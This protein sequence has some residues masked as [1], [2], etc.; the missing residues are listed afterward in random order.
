MENLKALIYN[1]DLT[2]YQRGLAVQEF[3]KLLKDQ[4]EMFE[5]MQYYMEYCEKNGYVTPMDW[6]EKYK[7]F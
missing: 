1:R 6:I 5:N 7:H 4:K 3:E 2:V